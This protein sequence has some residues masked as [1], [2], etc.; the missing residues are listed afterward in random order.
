MPNTSLN[1]L[2]TLGLQANAI[3]NEMDE[4][5]PPLSAGP[6][7]EIKHIMYRAGQRS[8]VDWLNKR[9]EN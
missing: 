6:N 5:F 9:L 8:V 7:D 3:L 2:E 1:T 4:T